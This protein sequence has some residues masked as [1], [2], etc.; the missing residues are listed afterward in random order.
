LLEQDSVRDTDRARRIGALIAALVDVY[1]DR[2][3]QVVQRQIEE[4]GD[5]KELWRAVASRLAVA[6]TSRPSDPEPTTF[7]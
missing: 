3:P 6:K 1:G 2:A 4:G 7:E 5:S